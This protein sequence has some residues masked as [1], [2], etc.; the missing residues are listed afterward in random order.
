[1][2]VVGGG[3]G[4]NGAPTHHPTLI[5]YYFSCNS[6]GWYHH[7]TSILLLP[8]VYRFV[9]KYIDERLVVL[10]DDDRSDDIFSALTLF[11][12][13]LILSPLV[14]AGQRHESR[15]ARNAAVGEVDLNWS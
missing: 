15:P 14:C 3:G 11:S 8:P 7:S 4:G 9:H 2:V 1:V 6:T 5:R 10:Q 13:T 12:S